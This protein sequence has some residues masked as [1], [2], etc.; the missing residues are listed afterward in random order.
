MA[1]FL[2]SHVKHNKLPQLKISSYHIFFLF[3]TLKENSYK[4]LISAGVSGGAQHLN[5]SL[6]R[7]STYIK[8]L[9]YTMY[10]F[11]LFQVQSNIIY[12]QQTRNLFKKTGREPCICSNYREKER[13]RGISH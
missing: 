5:L 6:A 2:Y 1:T 8:F 3:Y 4:L 11:Y 10:N 7:F 12:F 9:N 13:K